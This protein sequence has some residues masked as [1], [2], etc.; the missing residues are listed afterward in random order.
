MKET[1]DRVEVRETADTVTIETWLGPPEEDGFWPGCESVGTGFP[2]RVVLD[3]PLG[4]RRFV[5][6]ACD[7]DRYAHWI[8]CGNSSDNRW[9]FGTRPVG[10]SP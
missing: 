3:S 7:L 5:D 4:T 2:V 9:K 1:F 6:P 10:E 8:V